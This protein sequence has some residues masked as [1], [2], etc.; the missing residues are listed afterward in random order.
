MTNREQFSLGKEYVQYCMKQ[1]EEDDLEL[2]KQ[3]LVPLF[4]PK[5]PK[6]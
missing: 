6:E 1:L 5:A 3:F 4:P 2:A